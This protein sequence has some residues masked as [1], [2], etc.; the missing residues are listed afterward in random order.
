MYIKTALAANRILNHMGLIESKLS[1]IQNNNSDSS[2]FSKITKQ[3]GHIELQLTDKCNLNC[4]HC[5]FRNLGD[6]HF[7][8]DWL[9]IISK[10]IKPKAISLIGG[11]E[12]TCYPNFSDA[13]YKLANNLTN[14][15]LG[16]ITNGV[17]IP[18]G[19]WHNHLSWLRVSYYAIENDKYCGKPKKFQKSVLNNIFWYLNNTNVENIGVSFLLHR[20]SIN[21]T[22]QFLVDIISN[23]EK[24]DGD[25]KRFNIQFKPAFIVVKPAS[26]DDQLHLTNLNFLA[27]KN[28]IYK[29]YQEIQ[30]LLN[31][32]RFYYNIINNHSNYHIFNE[33]LDRNLLKM[34]QSTDPSQKTPKNFD[35]CYYCL[36]FQLIT[37]SG[38][39]YP[40]P[41]LAEFRDKSYST[42][43]ISDIVRSD[44][45]IYNFYTAPTLCCNS[46][47][48]R[49]TEHN[50]I[51]SGALKT[52]MYKN[53][54]DDPFF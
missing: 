41:T 13:I 26:I 25:I 47:F 1:V 4:F 23:L 27:D 44:K 14:V 54:Y 39:M 42:G 52:K 46:R 16:L 9:E 38:D 22:V 3:F 20:K 28:Q 43:N 21:Q 15:K 18:K 33:L 36:A 2:Y 50:S 53:K 10:V 24:F 49:Y 29:V 34:I 7:E 48:C 32:N 35:H 31:K 19:N 51:I 8:Y 37:P 17:I 6:D 40:C 45:H 11:G 30:S 5:H 12:P